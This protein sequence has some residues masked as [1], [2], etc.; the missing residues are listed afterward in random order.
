M[1]Q[2][3]KKTFYMIMY[4]L[5]GLIF[6]YLMV[7]RDDQPVGLIFTQI[8]LTPIFLLILGGLPTNFAKKLNESKK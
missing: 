8:I 6:F 2:I 4:A 3:I 5:M 1:G 7:R